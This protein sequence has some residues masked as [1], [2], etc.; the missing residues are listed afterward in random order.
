M[1][2]VHIIRTKIA[3]P[4]QEIRVE[5]FNAFQV[6][7]NRRKGIVRVV[8]YGKRSFIPFRP[9][10]FKGVDIA[11]L[12]LGR[13]FIV[14]GFVC[15][16]AGC[17]TVII[18][19][20][21]SQ[22]VNSSGDEVCFERIKAKFGIASNF[23]KSRSRSPFDPSGGGAVQRP[24]DRRASLGNILQEWERSRETLGR[25]VL[26]VFCGGRG[27]RSKK[28]GSANSGG[29]DRTKKCAAIKTL[30]V[31]HRKTPILKKQRFV[32]HRSRKQ[33]RSNLSADLRVPLLGY[34][35]WVQI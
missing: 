12:G 33:R 5:F 6:P 11:I 17:R 29:S 13:G 28:R 8:H 16:G 10:R 26:R 32:F 31:T 35:N 24:R 30:T 1:F 19:C 22:T 14:S 2:R 27:L 18:L 25:F 9:G 15:K 20:V 3:V 7:P 21:R 23:T 4:E 34:Q